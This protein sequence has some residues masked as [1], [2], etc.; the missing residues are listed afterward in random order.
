MRTS[1]SQTTGKWKVSSAARAWLS[2][3]T[4]T[5]FV[6]AQPVY[7]IL[8]SNPEFISVRHISNTRLL[9]IILVF[10][11]LPAT[12]LFL[13][14]LLCDRIHRV[15]SRIFFSILFFAFSLLL[16]WQVHNA[17][18]PDWQ[19]FRRSYLLWFAPAL[20]IGLA[21]LKFPK[22]FRSFLLVLS[23]VV[24]FLPALFLYHT[25]RK[26]KNPQP[27]AIAAN[28]AIP[29]IDGGKLH[30][31]FILLF[32]ELTLR[33]LVN[34]DGEID[35]RQFPNFH[36]LS[37]ESHWFRSATANADST[38]TSIPVILTGDYHRTEDLGA[39]LDRNNILA[40]LAPY[41][42]IYVYEPEPFL[43]SSSVYHCPDQEAADRF[44]QLAWDIVCL[45]A[46]RALPKALT[47]NLPPM[48]MSWG[49]F[50]YVS[51]HERMF[52]RVRRF[53][54]FLHSI[55]RRSRRPPFYFFHNELPHSPYVFEADG[56]IYRVAP[57]LLHAE[58]LND[59]AILREL[60]NRYLMQVAFTDRQL[61]QFMAR[62]KEAGLYDS[63]LVIVTADHGI[64]FRPQAA[65]RRVNVAD[66][67]LVLRVPLFIK[68]P[69][70]KVGGAS[71]SDVQHIDLVPT[72]AHDAGLA[73]PWKVAGREVFGSNLSVRSRIA[74]DAGGKRLELSGVPPFSSLTFPDPSSSPLVG[75]K[76]EA[77]RINPDENIGGSL[78]TLSDWQVV[79]TA[80]SG[81]RRIYMNG[82]AALLDTRQAPRQVA[83]TVNNEIVSVTSPCFS[84]PSVASHFGD[85]SLLRTGWSTSFSTRTL[86]D[87]ANSVAAYVVLDEGKKELAPLRHNGI[88]EVWQT[89]P[90][91]TAVTN[92]VG[93]GIT[94]FGLNS[95]SG[96]AGSLDDLSEIQIQTP[97]EG[98]EFTIKVE[99]WAAIPPRGAIP[100]RI[101]V[102]LNNKI[103]AVAFPH[104]ER[105]DVAEYL[106]NSKFLRTGWRA[107][108]SSRNLRQG[109]N[110]VG[111]YALVE[112]SEKRLAKLNSRNAIIRVS[113]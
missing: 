102:S 50:E 66:A 82:W 62:L 108:F 75:Q 105:P 27:P 20:L 106:E 2:I 19:P 13:V 21:S 9:L 41:Y 86:H 99:G 15:L 43:C 10:N 54:S 103:V 48:E 71:D 90:N 1:N 58:F 73:V 69:F 42:D 29:R 94:E 64:S 80:E 26:A 28:Q 46:V 70:Q 84:R 14:W 65:G 3:L 25:W 30:P 98:V 35:A 39:E 101:A 91:D 81:D 96:V 60:W 59:S 107:F 40:L 87:G 5:T 63:S 53:D 38:Y 76:I 112:S 67:D 88:N 72:I 104:I 44:S 33:A 74:Y 34:E 93:K 32:D 11:L 17:Y 68:L 49:P 24:L 37:Q 79:R 12:V 78:D 92:L 110:R 4:L 22:G 57:Y 56:K 83:I 47:L 109:E 18:L 89:A 6:I 77:F 45:M 16:L 61:G 97:P 95:D 52:R 55:G 36:E 7:E 51:F 85:M 23:P 100:K 113:D 8:A 31:V 111:A